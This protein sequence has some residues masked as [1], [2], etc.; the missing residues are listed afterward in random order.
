MVANDSPPLPEDTTLT[1]LVLEANA[2]KRCHVQVPD[3]PRPVAAIAYR[4]QF[5]SYVKSFP[6]NEAAEKAARRLLAKGD[7]VILIPSPKGMALWAWE[8][9]A[10][11]VRK[12]AI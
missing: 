2:V 1:P 3:L 8:P 5:Y 6:E 10:E 9:D 4:K 7:S 12:K 11:P